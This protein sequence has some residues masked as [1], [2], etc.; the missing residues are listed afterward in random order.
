MVEQVQNLRVRIQI[1]QDAADTAELPE[2]D[3]VEAQLIG[4]AVG[5]AD[6]EAGASYNHK[7]GNNGNNIAHEV[8]PSRGKHNAAPV[9]AAPKVAC[10]HL[11]LRAHWKTL[12]GKEQS[13]PS[14]GGP[15]KGNRFS[16]VEVA[17]ACCSIALQGLGPGSQALAFGSVAEI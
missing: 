3:A 6:K 16:L 8:G 1:A 2:G 4:S 10:S 7:E 14:F 17:V 12:P 9:A 5:I 11:T 13:H 15:W